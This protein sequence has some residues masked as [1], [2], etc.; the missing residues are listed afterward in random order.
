M[1]LGLLLDLN[2]EIIDYKA[3]LIF[4]YI[5]QS[6]PT[7]MKNIQN[8]FAERKEKYKKFTLSTYFS[9]KSLQVDSKNLQVTADGILTSRFGDKGFEVSPV[10][11]LLSYEWA[12]R[13]LRL[14]EFVRVKEDKD[15][16]ES[17]KVPK[18]DTNKN[19]N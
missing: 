15:D 7:Y 3:S 6:H 8:Y 18:E 12:G 16:K 14:K 5:S 11:Y 10:S 17:K 2:P 4:K 1:Y 9:I 13:Q 19:H